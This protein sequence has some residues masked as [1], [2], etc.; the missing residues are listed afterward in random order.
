MEWS[1]EPLWTIAECCEY[2]NCTR[3]TVLLMVG[4]GEIPYGRLGPSPSGDLR[5]DPSPS[6]DLRFD[7]SLIRAAESRIQAAINRRRIRAL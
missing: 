2:L 3:N 6:G 5:F 1:E 7:P 4:R